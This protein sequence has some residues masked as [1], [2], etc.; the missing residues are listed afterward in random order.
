MAR[1]QYNDLV[2]KRADGENLE[3]DDINNKTTPNILV[4]KRRQLSE[5]SFLSTHQ[6]G[7]LHSAPGSPHYVT[8]F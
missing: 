6:L 4:N 5:F 7:E 3:T 1:A 2:L 8:V